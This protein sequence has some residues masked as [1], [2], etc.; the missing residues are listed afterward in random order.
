MNERRI[1]LWEE[2]DEGGG[3]GGREDAV[4]RRPLNQPT[5]VGGFVVPWLFFEQCQLIP[6]REVRKQSYWFR[7]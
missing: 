6:T 1:E 7:N 4:I 2:D 3:D 5:F